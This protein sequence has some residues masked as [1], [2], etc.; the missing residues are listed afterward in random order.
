MEKNLQNMLPAFQTLY[1][2]TEEK[3]PQCLWDF[4]GKLIFEKIIIN[5]TK[6]MGAEHHNN[7]QYIIYRVSC[8]SRAAGH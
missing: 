4:K 2:E 8:S 1:I 3:Y 5:V 6:P 7:I